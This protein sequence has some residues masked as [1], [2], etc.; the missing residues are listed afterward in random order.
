MNRLTHRTRLPIEP[1]TLLLCATIVIAPQLFG[2]AFPWS[3]LAIAALSLTSLAGALWVRRSKA[4]R[5]LDGLFIVMAFA[6]VWT[7]CQSVP[8]S[9]ALAEALELVS[10]E[11][12]ARLEDL[13]WVSAIPLTVSQDP[14][15]TRLQVLVGISVL[16]PFIAAR[17]GGVSGL[18]PIAAATVVSAVLIGFVGLLH[19]AA[20]IDSVF[21]LYAPRFAAPNLLT[22]LMN[23]N[24]L[25]GFSLL[26]ALIAAGLAAAGDGPRRRFWAAASTFCA[27]VVALTLSRGAIGSLLFGFLLLAAWLLS[28]RRP[29][30]RRAAIPVAVVGAAGA[31]VVA[32]AGLE[33]ILRRFETQGF[34]K[35]A[36]A[37]QGFQ[38]LEGSAWWLGVGRGAFSSA[39]VSEQGSFG[40]FTHPENILVQWATEWGLPLTFALIAVVLT[41]IWRRFRKTDEPLV[42]AACV[43]IFA[44]SLHNLVDFSLEMPG[45]VAVVAA[46]LGALLPAPNG[47]SRQAPSRWAFVS[48]G[49][50]VVALGVLGPRARSSDTQSIVDELTRA[51]EADDP[52]RFEAALQHGLALHPSEPAIAVLAGTYA[53]A[54]KHSDA[55]R[56][57][58]IAMEEAP[59]WAAPHAVAAQLLF[60][61]GRIDQALVEMR[62]AE[63]RQGR[64]AYAVLCEALRRSPRMEYVRRAAPSDEGRIDYLERAAA[65]PGLDAEL[66]VE[67]DSEILLLDPNRP[68]SVLRESHRLIVQSRT[69]EALTLLQRAVNEHGDERTLR[70]ALIRAHL[71]NGDPERATSALEEAKAAGLDGRVLLQAQ[72]RVESSEG[73]ADEM[74]ATVTRLRGQARGDAKLIARSF[75]LEGELE[76]ELGNTDEA[77]SAYAAA[78]SADPST[79]ALQ[80][81]A[82]LALTSGRPTQARRLYRELCVRQPG[83]YVC[84]VEAQ[85]AKE[86]AKTPSAPRVP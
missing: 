26:A 68:A 85:L 35:L 28:A 1:D 8:L 18:K 9:S 82:Q 84:D 55:P 72:A 29:D 7:C 74:R 52:T 70:V 66:R 43:G 73:R 54:K 69:D 58:S 15:S 4:S 60:E 33:P 30:R 79:P 48:L 31:G 63:Q 6:W 83:G 51:M 11:N 75:L 67:I 20:G 23:G 10:V 42:A 53:G 64:A 47:L 16:A 27:I 81:A 44:L 2:G 65:C 77:L 12:A 19:R 80:R 76:A 24:H 39:F 71:S 62:E 59:G 38:L 57:L 45:V 13:A 34:E 37:A 41:T 22:P 40:R 36:V 78:D 5:I 49:L 86:Q 61:A 17:L 21:G 14:G 32:F 25:G 3:V 46:L 50:F 56:W